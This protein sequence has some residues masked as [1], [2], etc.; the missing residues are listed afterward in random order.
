VLKIAGGVYLIYL[1]WKIFKT[2]GISSMAGE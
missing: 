1:A 2:P